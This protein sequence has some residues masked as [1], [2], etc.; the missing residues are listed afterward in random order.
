MEISKT[1]LNRKLIMISACSLLS[2]SLLQSA[3]AQQPYENVYQLV[4]EIYKSPSTGDSLIQN[5]QNLFDNRFHSCLNELLAKFQAAGA[6]HYQYCDSVHADPEYRA[7]CKQD[8]EPMKM[9]HLLRTIDSVISGQARWSDSVMGQAMTLGEQA[10][11]PAQ[12]RE[13]IDG[14]MPPMKPQLVCK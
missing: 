14:Y 4:Y 12:Y 2:C 9:H 11:P 6:N 8:N 13:L 10:L 5:K 7:K 1:S 3:C